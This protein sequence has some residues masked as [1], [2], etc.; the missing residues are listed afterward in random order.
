MRFR[1][2]DFTLD[3]ETLQLLRGS[4]PL[5]L[6]PK[7][8]ELLTLLLERRPAVVSKSEI[9]VQL[10]PDTFV[11][12]GNV[13]G[14]VTQIRQALRDARAQS[15]FIRT[16]HGVGYAFC[17]DAVPDHAERRR[18]VACVVWLNQVLPLRV[19]DNVLGRAPDSAVRIDAPGVSRHHARITLND[20]GALLEDLESKNGTHLRGRRLDAPAPLQ[21]G[22]PFRLG[23]QSLVFRRS[24]G[25]GTT[26]TE[27]DR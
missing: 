22:D 26:A 15:R 11:S 9:Q 5:H 6:E 18:P 14:L 17:G 7:A 19:G 3:R 10:L 20:E 21:D 16:V 12:E 25:D 8:F 4:E 1:F 2:A 13:T 24:P 27:P 23:S